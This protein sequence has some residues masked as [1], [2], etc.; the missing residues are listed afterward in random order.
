[1]IRM[2]EY[3]DVVVEVLKGVFRMRRTPKLR[4]IGGRVALIGGDGKSLHAHRLRDFF[5]HYN[6]DLDA[7]LS[8]SEKESIDAVLFVLCWRTSEIQLWTQPPI[9]DTDCRRRIVA[10][11]HDLEQGEMTARRRKGRCF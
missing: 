4:K 9:E 8:L 3:A 11:A 10:S 1:M 5:V 7:L 6:E 2:S